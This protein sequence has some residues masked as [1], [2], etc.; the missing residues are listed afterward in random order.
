MKMRTEF[1]GYTF[2]EHHITRNPDKQTYGK[3]TYDV[4]EDFIVGHETDDKKRA[5]MLK[6]YEA[7]KKISKT[8]RAA[9]AFVKKWFLSKYGTE[10]A[11][12]QKKQDAKKR[13]AAESQLIY[14]NSND[15]ED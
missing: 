13:A 11:D 3:L 9:Y 7:I 10:F 1:P 2:V 15:K 14:T 6:E 12:F 8:Q 4:M 5:A